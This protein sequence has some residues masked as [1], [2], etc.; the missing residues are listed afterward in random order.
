MVFFFNGKCFHLLSFIPTATP[1]SLER[2]ISSETRASKLGGKPL[3]SLNS[4]IYLSLA[5]SALR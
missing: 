1:L 2:K 4:S 5:G 3:A